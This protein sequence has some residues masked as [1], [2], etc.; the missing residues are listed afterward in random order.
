MSLREQL[1]AAMTTAMRSHDEVRRDALRMAVAALYNAEKAARRPLT[2][3]EDLGVLVHEMKVRRESLEAFRGGSRPDLAGKE[4]AAMAVLREFLPDQ[5]DDAGL[6]A[7]VAAAIAQAGA[8]SPRD[9]GAVMRLLAPRVKGR[10]DG[11]VV[12]ERVARELS[13]AGGARRGQGG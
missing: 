13:A 4:E 10:A 9:L 11:K 6:S 3:E 2:D 7:L 8:T 12:S 5:L 1:Q